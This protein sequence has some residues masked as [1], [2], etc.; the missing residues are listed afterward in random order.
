MKLSISTCATELQITPEGQV[1]D[2]AAGIRQAAEAGFQ[3]VD[4][5]LAKAAKFSR[6]LAQNNWRDWAK[7][8]REVADACGVTIEQ[9]HAHWFYIADE[10]SL[11]V[12]ADMEY[13]HR[14]VEAS[15]ILGNSPWVVTHPLS[16]AD[17]LG[18]NKARTKEFLK[19]L[20][21][22][23]GEIA[24]R[25]G[26]K[27]AA[28]NLFT[29]GMRYFGC[30]ADDLCWLMETLNDPFFGICWDF[31]HANKMGL[32]QAASLHQIAPYLRVTHVHDNK[33]VFDDHFFPYFGNVPWKKILPEIKKIGYN[34]NWN[35]ET[36]VTYH[37]IPQTMR[38]SALRFLHD[39]GE[40][41]IKQIQN[42]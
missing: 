42:A 9:T 13:L 2:A 27:I 31:G 38:I 1:F 24:S 34:G 33:A 40:D 35:F 28:E 7:Q 23:L 12:A 8:M 10:N 22:E 25:C 30:N 21:G 15:A 3:Y 18:Y 17:S 4:F 26:A 5:N 32:D 41:M 19:K 20:Y 6:P 39:L 37:T 36:H 16:L 29:G 11:D 14:S